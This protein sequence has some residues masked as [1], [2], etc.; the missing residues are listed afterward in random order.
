MA[1]LMR[2]AS[3]YAPTSTSDQSRP[4]ALHRAQHAC[5]L[6]RHVCI[7]QPRERRNGD[8]VLSDYFLEDLPQLECAGKQAFGRT[9]CYASFDSQEDKPN[10]CSP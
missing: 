1:Y 8:A 4:F 9:A 6:S 7:G 10:L 5:P 2:A 3:S